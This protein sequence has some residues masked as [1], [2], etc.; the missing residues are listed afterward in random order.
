MFVVDALANTGS[1]GIPR[2]GQYSIYMI[3]LIDTQL[4]LALQASYLSAWTTF[5][6]MTFFT[7]RP[8]P[9]FHQLFFCGSARLIL[10]PHRCHLPACSTFTWNAWWGC[11]AG[12]HLHWLY[13]V[14]I[15]WPIE[16]L[17]VMVYQPVPHLHELF[18]VRMLGRY[19]LYMHHIYRDY[20]VLIIFGMDIPA[21]IDFTSDEV[22]ACT[23]FTSIIFLR[24]YFAR[25][26]LTGM[27]S[28]TF[29]SDIFVQEYPANSVSTNITFTGLGYICINYILYECPGR[30]WLLREALC[31]PV[32]HL[33]QLL[34]CGIPGW[35]CLYRHH[36]QRP[37][38]HL[39]QLYLV[40]MS[41]LIPTPQGCS[42]S[43]C[44]IFTS[45]IFLQGYL[46]DTGSTGMAFTGLDH[47]CINYIWYEC[48]GWYWPHRHALCWPVPYYIKYFLQRYSADTGATG[49]TFTSLDH[50]C[51]VYIL[52]K[53][54]GQYWPHRYALCQPVPYL[55]QIFFAGIFSQYW[56]YRHHIHRPGPHLHQLYLVWMSWPILTPQACSLSAC[57]TFTS[58]IFCRDT[59]PILVLQASHLPAWTT[60]APIIFCMNVSANADPTGMLFVGLYHIYIRYFFAGI[61]GRYWYYRYDIHRPGPHLH[62]LYLVWMSWPILT[63]QAC[64]LSA[65]TIL[66]QIFFAGIFS[67]YW[68][69]RHHIHRPGPYLHQ[70]YLVC[71]S[72][73]ILTPQACSLSAC[74]IYISDI[75]YGSTW[76]ILVLQASHSLAWTTSVLII[77]VWKSPPI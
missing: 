38:L 54:L 6:S 46:A 24:G 36:I 31:R 8:V 21:D 53:C 18:L 61:F 77:F 74:T 44:T 1:T 45:D 15:S 70:L 50:I 65:Y 30:Y 72:W 16:V 73:P 55:H 4:V 64:P 67:R 5:A 37:G 26:D 69:Y 29:T 19:W 3:C 71:M 20:V 62:Q 22:S 39:H 14:W 40:W 49:I 52:Y 41:R 2:V 43:A 51:I 76:P 12:K 60:S 35:H 57:T 9:H 25:T 68:C 48:L 56:C 59:R 47:I 58:D 42:L 13:L 66:H 11:P 10:T 23:T 32:P 75:L 7:Y 34:F 33:H 17:R 63:P 28:V 27:P